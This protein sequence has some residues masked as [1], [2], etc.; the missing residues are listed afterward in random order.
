MLASFDR[1]V[2]PNESIGRAIVLRVLASPSLSSSG[3]MR[4]ASALPSSTPHW[5][6][7]SMLQIAPCVKTLCSYS[8]ISFPSVSGVSRSS[9]NR[10]RWDDFLRTCDGAQAIRVSLRT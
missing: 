5:S 7:E 2:M 9:Q 3:M 10:V 4:L 1:A 6:K 8:A